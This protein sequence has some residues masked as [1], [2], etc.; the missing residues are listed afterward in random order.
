MIY[1]VSY[2]VIGT[3]DKKYSSAHGKVTITEGY[4]TFEDIRKIVAIPRGLK[5]ENIDIQAIIK[6]S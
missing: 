6:E 1:L 3:G 4:S 5:A 2:D